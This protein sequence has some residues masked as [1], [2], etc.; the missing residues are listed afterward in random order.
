MAQE[1]PLPRTQRT[2]LVLLSTAETGAAET[3]GAVY[4]EVVGIAGVVAAVAAAG[5]ED[6]QAV[7]HIAGTAV[8]G[9]EVLAA[10]IELVLAVTELHHP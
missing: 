2:W 3:V 4:I 6:A 8:A 7:A 5:I 10:D 9:V 1:V